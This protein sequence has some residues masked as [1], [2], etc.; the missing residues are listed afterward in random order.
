ML[1]VVDV[2]G[3]DFTQVGF[4]AGLAGDFDSDG[5]V[6]GADLLVWQRGFPGSFDADDLTDWKNGFGMTEPAS[7]AGLGSLAT[8][9]PEPGS[10]LLSMLAG[11]ALFGKMRCPRR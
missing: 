5:D 4:A 3:T 11:V 1:E 9:V 10:L 6:D 2:D 8:P 7:I